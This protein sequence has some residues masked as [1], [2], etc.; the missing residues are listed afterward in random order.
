MLKIDLHTHIL[1]RDWPDLA[2][3]YGYGREMFIRPEHA[4]E[5]RK[6]CM[7]MIQGDRLF[8]RVWPN[9]YEP[10]AVLDECRRNGVDVQVACT[11]P[12][13][14]SYWAEPGDT[15]DLARLLNDDLA[16][17]CRAHPPR[18]GEPGFIGLAHVPLNDTD[19]AIKELERGVNDL[20]FPGAQIGSHLEPNEFTGRA[21]D[22]NLDDPSLFPFFEAAQD[23]GAAIFVHPWAMLGMKE[24]PKYWLPW[25]VGM[26]AETCRAICGVIFSGMLDKLPSLRIG[27][28]HGGGTFPFTIGRIEHGYNTRPDLVAVDGAHNPRDYLGRFYVDTAVHDPLALQTLIDLIGPDRI[29]MGSDYPFPLG[30]HEPGALVESMGLADATKARMLAG[31]AIEFLGLSN[32]WVV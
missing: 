13:M 7:R 28:A 23:L 26:P 10:D 16:E 30:E 4:T 1:P 21:H 24:M 11:V 6:P 14:F 15:A 5:G 22:L 17:T 27:F 31:S 3:R 29:A 18:P 25:L 8:R 12:V 9:C 19:L 2:Q 20:G 32:A